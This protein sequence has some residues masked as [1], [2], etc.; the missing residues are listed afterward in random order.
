MPDKK[1]REERIRRLELSSRQ[2]DPSSEQRRSWDNSAHRLVDGFLDTLD[3]QPA[4]RQKG[5]ET[6]S[7]P[8]GMF[9]EDGDGINELLHYLNE[10]VHETGINAASGGHLGYIP[11]GGLYGAAIGDYLAA[12]FNRYAG[13]YYAAPG[14]VKMENALIRWTGKLLGYT[15][16]FAGNITSGG[17]MA[18]LI[19]LATARD[20]HGISGKNLSE[21]VIYTSAQVHHCVM[22]D[23]KVAGMGECIVRS[24]P[25]DRNF[26][27]DASALKEKILADRRDGLHPFLLI[28]TAGTTDAGAVDPLDELARIS[29]D[30]KLWFHV[31]AAY[32]GYFILTDYGKT[33][34]RG[35]EHADSIV[36]DPHKSLF[37]PF[38]TGMVLVKKKQHLLQAHSSHASYMQDSYAF[39]QEVSPA[40]LSPELTKHFRGLRMWLPLRLHGIR[41]FRDCLDEKLELARYF[42]D[43]VQKL[44]FLT[45]PEPELS[46]VLFRHTDGEEVNKRIAQM[47]LEDGKLFMSTTTLDGIFWLRIAILSFRTH[48]DHINLLISSLSEISGRL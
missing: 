31:D 22:K 18:N 39:D 19:A 25:V 35:I 17:S 24:V 40:D 32:G 48:I 20:A 42:Y 21:T 27:M 26:R 10:N 38:G 43:E 11:G 23:L 6:A 36:V 1:D 9:S 30:E 3:G 44:G 4:F 41:P 5:Y 2:L 13:V 45:G 37:L 34:L 7:F 46:V 47:L 29:D 14:A 15:G 8:E 33:I 28:A 12:A 16:D